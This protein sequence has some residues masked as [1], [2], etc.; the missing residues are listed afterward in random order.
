MDSSDRRVGAIVTV[1]EDDFGVMS[2]Y[3]DRWAPTGSST[4]TATATSVTATAGLAQA[5]SGAYFLFDR[6][7]VKLG[8][9]QPPMHKA[10]PPNGDYERGFVLAEIAV[11]VLHPSCVG[12]GYNITQ[13]AI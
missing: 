2:V 10:L 8:V 4:V 11:K 5:A 12:Y 7:M 6:K 13:T 1:I 9:F 3:R